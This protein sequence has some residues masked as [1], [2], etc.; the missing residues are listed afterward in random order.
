M[1]TLS[2]EHNYIIKVWHIGLQEY[3][4]H[5]ISDSYTEAA[6]WAKGLHPKAAVFSG[7]GEMLET[8]TYQPPEGKTA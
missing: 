4:T 5:A 7:K 1:T 2:I 8:F 3:F 6:Q